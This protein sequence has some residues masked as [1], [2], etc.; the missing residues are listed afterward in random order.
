MRYGRCRCWPAGARR[1]EPTLEILKK[2]LNN[3]KESKAVRLCDGGHPGAA[4]EAQRIG[5][6]VFARH[7]E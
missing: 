6:G 7:A 2:M 5:R 3:P 1:A 4:M